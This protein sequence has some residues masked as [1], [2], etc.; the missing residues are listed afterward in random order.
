MTR[1]RKAQPEEIK[2]IRGNPG[3]RRLLAL[4]AARKQQRVA[5]A[6]PPKIETPKWLNGEREAAIFRLVV[7]E[8]QQNRIARPTDIHAYGR[9]AHYMARWIDAKEQLGDTASFYQIESNHGKRLALHPLLV[10]MFRCEAEIT[11]QEDR[12]GL[13]PAARQNIIRGMSTLAPGADLFGNVPQP[14]A[15]DDDEIA[16]ATAIEAESPLGFLQGSGKPN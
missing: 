2:E 10:V 3:K 15:D 9:W 16:Q 14:P 11:K 7:D 8:Y 12:L 13:N 5:P 6:P 4:E 1:G